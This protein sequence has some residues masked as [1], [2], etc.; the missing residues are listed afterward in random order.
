MIIDLLDLLFF[1]ECAARPGDMAQVKR[2]NRLP[3]GAVHGPAAAECSAGRG[4]AAVG[5]YLD[6][7]M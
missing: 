7:I 3:P 6:E 2:G 1:R 4:A 5:L